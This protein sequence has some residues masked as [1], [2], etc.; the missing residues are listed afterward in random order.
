MYRDNVPIATSLTPAHRLT[1][2]AGVTYQYQVSAV[3]QLYL[4]SA[5]HCGSERARRQFTPIPTNLAAAIV[6]TTNIQLSWTTSADL[7]SG[8]S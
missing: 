8:V 7:Q 2:L 1:V 4:E 3:N 5:C 6:S